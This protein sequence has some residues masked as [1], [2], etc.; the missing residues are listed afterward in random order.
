MSGGLETSMGDAAFLANLGIALFAAI[1]LATLV[2]FCQ[3][4]LWPAFH[5]YQLQLSPKQYRRAIFSYA[6]LP[7]AVGF[8]LFVSCAAV[9]SAAGFNLVPRHCH[10]E[11]NAN[12]CLPHEPTPVSTS[13]SLAFLIGLTLMVLPIMILF[14]NRLYAHGKVIRELVANSR[15]DQ[16]LDAWVVRSSSPSA[17][18]VGIFR[19]RVFVSDGLLRSLPSNQVDI[20]LGHEHGHAR[21]A[22][23]LLV[24][25]LQLLTVPF[26][27]NTRRGL[28][29]EFLLSV[30][31]ECDQRAAEQCGDSLAVADTLVRLGRMRLE[32]PG[33]ADPPVQLPIF[34]AIGQSL[35]R[36]VT[37]LVQSPAHSHDG[38]TVM[39]ERLIC[40]AV[41]LSCIIAEPVHHVL[42]QVLQI[43][44][45]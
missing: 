27:R 18:C 2:A 3:S 20:V 17:F 22:D 37:W 44:A 42:E 29:T 28:M 45:P 23:A 14:I 10:Y 21:R 25:A 5:Q 11:L 9:P 24:F 39:V 36:R 16:A 41:I 33:F 31:Y 40:Y 8:A 34:S 43:F 7:I 15:Y 1:G 13:V 6:S 12:L 26:L 4:L 38:I 19:R 35:E 30:E 32:Q